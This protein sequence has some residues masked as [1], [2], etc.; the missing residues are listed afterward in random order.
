[1]NK[2]IGPI[3]NFRLNISLDQM[4]DDRYFKSM[5]ENYVIVF[6]E[7]QG[8]D[9]TDID[10]LKKQVTID[11]NDYRPLGTNEVF[12][13]RQ[14]CSFIGATNRPVAEQIVDSTGMRRF[15][16]INCL[17]RLDW[18][19]LSSIDYVAMWKGIDE[20]KV[21]GYILPQISS[22]RAKQEN[23]V[24]K[25]QITMF[26]E[27]NGLIS[28]D[29]VTKEVTAAMMYQFYRT[30]AENNGFKPMD[31]SWFGRRLSSRGISSSAKKIKDKTYNVYTVPDTAI[32]CYKDTWEDLLTKNTTHLRTM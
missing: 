5:S 12:K 4:G 30:W 1:M 24:A 18:A 13:V 22:I 7:M 9:R 23:M 6:D 19:V 16:Q 20:S 28:R 2:L 14:S 25:D 26:I 8:A 29:G 31:N 27:S 10:A 11:D 21:D 32:T 17:D 3:N 15:W